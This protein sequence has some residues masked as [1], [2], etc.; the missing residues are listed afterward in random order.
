MGVWVYLMKHKGETRDHL[1]SFCQMLETQFKRKVKVIRSDQG[2]KF[3]MTDYFNEQGII[4]QMSCVQT[5]EQNARVERKHE[6]ILNVAR[7]LKFQSGLSLEHWSDCILHAVYLI[8]RIS[9]P[10]LQNQ[11]PYEK[12]FSQ[13]PDLRNL[14]VFGCL[15]YVSTLQHN[16]TKFHPT[17]CIFL[18]IHVGIKGYKVMENEAKQVFI[19]RDVIFYESIL[20]YKTNPNLDTYSQSNSNTSDSNSH[21]LPNNP[22]SNVPPNPNPRPD[23]A[24]ISYSGLSGFSC[25]LQDMVTDDEEE[26][27]IEGGEEDQTNGQIEEVP[28]VVPDQQLRRSTRERKAPIHLMDYHLSNIV[29]RHPIAESISYNNLSDEYMKF[30][31]SIIVQ[32]EPRNYQE[33]KS[34]AFW[35]NAMKDE[36]SAM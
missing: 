2:K 22:P 28:E 13:V 23:D 17:Q 25:S 16:R 12:L 3:H 5:P 7:S 8:N 6:N 9:T 31:L 35:V 33:A 27:E 20:P 34:E 32:Q 26:L 24:P 14:K 18:E 1:K 36:L 29:S 15:C 21:P 19:S 4:H 30:A 10:I 11:S